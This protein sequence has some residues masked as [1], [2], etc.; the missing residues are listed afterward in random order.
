MPRED[1]KNI[2]HLSYSQ[3]SKLRQCPTAWEFGYVKGIWAPSNPNFIVGNVYHSC[4][5]ASFKFKLENKGIDMDPDLIEDMAVTE[6]AKYLK[7]NN[8]NWRDVDEL[9]AFD[10]CLNMAYKY[11]TEITPTIMPTEVEKEYVVQI[12]DTD[13][14]F[15]LRLDLRDSKGII[16][17]HKS[18]KDMRQYSQASVDQDSQ[19]TATAFA[20]NEPIVFY[21]HIM[22]KYKTPKMVPMKTFR[23]RADI[24][25]FTEVVKKYVRM[26][27]SGIF[28]P[29]EDQW[30]CSP[31]YCD[32]YERCRPGLHKTVV[33]VDKEDQ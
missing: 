19:A 2:K 24:V 28:P 7:E 16:Y 3:I 9:Q 33:T 14:V 4:V 17:D 11:I 1:L 30:S 20:L 25:W 10:L 15:V 18:A 23:T 8:V 5:E 27:K 29:N 31:L 22:L 26:I 12:D 6:W 21:N 13:T 32:Y